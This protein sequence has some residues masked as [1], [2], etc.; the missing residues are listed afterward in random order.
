MLFEFFFVVCLKG[1]NKKI[2]FELLLV[3]LEKKR[4]R[5]INMVNIYYVM[6]R[7][8]CWKKYFKKCICMY[9]LFLKSC[10]G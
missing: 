6:F 1:G 7:I 10:V 4:L 5:L 3:V 2:V 8:W 9:V